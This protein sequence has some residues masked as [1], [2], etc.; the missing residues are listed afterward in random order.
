MCHRCV[1]GYDHHCDWLNICIGKAN[2]K[3]YLAFIIVLW[4][5]QVMIVA[6]AVDQIIRQ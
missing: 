4:L 2:N 6:M 5:L 1:K 3:R